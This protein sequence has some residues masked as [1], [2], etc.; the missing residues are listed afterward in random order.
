ME[1]SDGDIAGQRFKVPD[2]MKTAKIVLALR[3]S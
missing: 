1:S 3:H 2:S